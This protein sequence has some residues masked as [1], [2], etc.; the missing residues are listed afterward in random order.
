MF[1]CRRKCVWIK[2]AGQQ[3]RQEEWRA[4]K[5][6]VYLVARIVLSGR[7]ECVYVAAQGRVLQGRHAFSVHV[8]GRVLGSPSGFVVERRS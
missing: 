7:Q 5:Q 4:L 8:A 1:C 3:E 6:G 2:A